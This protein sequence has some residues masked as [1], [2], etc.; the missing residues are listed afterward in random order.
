[1]TTLI[2]LLGWKRVAAFLGVLVLAYGLGLGTGY[3]KATVRC[4][5]AKAHETVN[6]IKTHDKIEKEVMRLPDPELDERLS[7]WMRD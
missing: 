4:E 6:S 5:T 1:M 2:D 7:R 3:Y